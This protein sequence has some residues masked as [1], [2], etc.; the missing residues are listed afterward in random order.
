MG[1]VLGKLD[2]KNGEIDFDQ[3]RITIDPDQAMQQREA[4]LLHEATH[5]AIHYGGARL[6]DDVEEAAVLALESVL[7]PFLKDTRNH[8]FLLRLMGLGS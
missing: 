2:N 6:N 1:I 7:Y 4:T 5:G 8:W 3:C